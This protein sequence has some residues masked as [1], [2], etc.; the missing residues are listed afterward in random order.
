MALDGTRRTLALV[1]AFH[2]SDHSSE[3]SPSYEILSR[4][5]HPMEVG[6]RPMLCAAALRFTRGAVAVERCR[7]VYGTYLALSD[8]TLR[9]GCTVRDSRDGVRA[10]LAPLDIGV[11][12]ILSDVPQT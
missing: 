12:V 3:V 9:R 11:G 7:G 2:I 1:R 5:A 10:M 6:S 8:G 4:M